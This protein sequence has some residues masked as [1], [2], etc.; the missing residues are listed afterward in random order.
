VPQ[1]VSTKCSAHRIQH[2]YGTECY[3]DRQKEE[4]MKL[5][6]VNSPYK[7][8]LFDSLAA[9]AEEFDI[10]VIEVRPGG[11]LPALSPYER[12]YLYRID[13]TG[14]GLQQERTLFDTYNCVTLSNPNRYHYKQL[15]M[16]SALGIPVTP[17]EVI[18]KS[19]SDKEIH[20]KIEK[21]GGFPI[22]IRAPDRTYGGKGIV[23]I[24][25]YESF[26]SIKDFIFSKYTQL[27]VAKYIKHKYKGRIPVLNGMVLPS[28][29]VT[30]PENDF[31]SF[32]HE[33]H[34]TEK[35][36]DDA[37][38]QVALDAAKAYPSN[39]IGVDVV[40]DEEGNPMIPEVNYPWDF[41]NIEK[42]TGYPVG[43]K[44]VE[45][46]RDLIVSSSAA[47]A[48]HWPS[49]GHQPQFILMN[50]K[51]V[52]VKHMELFRKAAA[53]YQM[54]IIEIDPQEPVPD[55]S[56]DKDYLLY[57]VDEAGYHL[58]KE[59]YQ[60]YTISSFGDDYPVYSR[61]GFNRNGHLKDHG[62]SYIH[63]RQVV[64]N[65]NDYLNSLIEETEQFPVILKVFADGPL[66][67]IKAD[68][69]K[70]LVSL[71]DYLW[72]LK[73]KVIIQPFIRIKHF[74]KF[75][76][77]GDRVIGSLE[78]IPR[79]KTVYWVGEQY[80]IVPKVFDETIAKEAVRAA[81]SLKLGFA[82]VEILIDEEG[83]HYINDVYFPPN[84]YDFFAQNNINVVELIIQHLLKKSAAKRQA[85]RQL[86]DKTQ[87]ER[88]LA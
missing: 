88:H 57:R 68:G 61:E 72:S 58:E 51:G 56:P 78:V 26:L 59:L 23:K 28:L 13:A 47:L 24:D 16:Y 40:F 49:K 5:I 1:R 53:L 63:R 70:S 75:L 12:Y 8:A 41:G 83:K 7:N 54:P 15:Q 37:V 34:I 36:F 42:F 66:Q 19:K 85:K 33:D 27:T 30:V 69:K 29:Q 64:K 39:F 2:A 46:L 38:V 44:V 73:K 65:T 32:N 55:L 21:L 80:F 82:S 71:L 11:K 86:M 10:P 77:L 81:Q 45:A 87:K 17:F 52:Y 62:F 60:K 67:Y 31:R 50:S 20:A 35:K 22:I 43:K 74:V 84:F 3:P 14:E 76:V 18:E 25:S 79:E 6:I 4:L 9:A 48:G